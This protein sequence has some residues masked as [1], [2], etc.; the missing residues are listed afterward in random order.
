ML[1]GGPGRRRALAAEHPDGAARGGD[2]D[3]QIAARPVE[4]RL[5]DLEHEA[6]L[7][8]LLE[9]LGATLLQPMTI[10][11]A[12]LPKYSTPKRV[13]FAAWRSSGCG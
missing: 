4:V 2:D 5:D 9:R 11:G 8:D 10:A 12:V 3:R 6:D 13:F 1:R 7:E